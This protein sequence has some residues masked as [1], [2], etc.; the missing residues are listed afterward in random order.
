MQ[1]VCSLP[2]AIVLQ[3]RL[4]LHELVDPL[5]GHGRP[6]AHIAGLTVNVALAPRR[7][8]EDWPRALQAGVPHVGLDAAVY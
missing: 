2:Q 1:G 6:C 7:Q 3:F 5:L 4:Q 8:N